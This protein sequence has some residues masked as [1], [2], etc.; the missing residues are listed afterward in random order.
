M[1]TRYCNAC[2]DGIIPATILHKEINFWYL[3][4]A[5]FFL[6]SFRETDVNNSL[7]YSKVKKD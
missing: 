2:Y 4:Y 5:L 3:V 1:P 6:T 7:C